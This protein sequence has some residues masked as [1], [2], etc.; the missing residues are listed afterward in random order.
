MFNCRKCNINQE[1]SLTIKTLWPCPGTLSNCPHSF[2]LPQRALS[3]RW[4]RSSCRTTR[5]RNIPHSLRALSADPNGASFPSDAYLFT[6]D[7]VVSFT[8]DL[9][10]CCPILEPSPPV[11]FT[12]ERRVLRL[13]GGAPPKSRRRRRDEQ[14][15]PDPFAAFHDVFNRRPAGSSSSS[16]EAAADDVTATVAT[17]ESVITTA[18]QDS[19]LTERRVAFADSRP[20]SSPHIPISKSRKTSLA[21]RRGE[22]DREIQASARAAKKAAT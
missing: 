6:E 22:L 20:G 18:V 17:G 21:E 3:L 2:V 5:S 19:S 12:V 15:Q 16:A 14:P 7:G 1:H 9:G 4:L 13:R 11:P 8:P 10:E